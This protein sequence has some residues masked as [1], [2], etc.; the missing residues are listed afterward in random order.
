MANVGNLA[1]CFTHMK[2][3]ARLGDS[4]GLLSILEDTQSWTSRNILPLKKKGK[5]MLLALPKSTQRKVRNFS[6]NRKSIVS[7]PGAVYQC[8]RSAAQQSSQILQSGTSSHS[9]LIFCAFPFI[10]S[11]ICTD[12]Q[13]LNER[14]QKKKL[15]CCKLNPPEVSGH[16]DV[17]SCASASPPIHLSVFG[18]AL[19]LLWHVWQRL[20][21]TRL[22]NYTN[23]RV[24]RCNWGW[25]KGCLGDI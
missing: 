2:Q 20:A 23:V 19:L 25:Q 9:H 14:Q 7:I 15:S 6:H 5:K 16:M 3:D 24:K 22:E 1:Q 10:C 13:C 17:Q 18:G 12:H 4:L 8:R 21:S 11:F